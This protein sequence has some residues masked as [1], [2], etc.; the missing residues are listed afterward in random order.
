MYIHVGTFE[1]VPKTSYC[2]SQQFDIQTRQKGHSI[3]LLPLFS[4]CSHTLLTREYFITG[5]TVITAIVRC[6]LITL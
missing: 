1:L 4:P 3:L 5:S 6:G 2:S